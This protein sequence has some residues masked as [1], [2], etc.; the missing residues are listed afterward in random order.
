MR[1][2]KRAQELDPLAQ[3]INYNVAQ[4]YLLKNAPAPAIEQC[5][6]IIELYPNYPRAHKHLGFAYLKQRHCEEATAE[7]LKAVELSGRAS[8]H[9]R[10]LGYCYAV[11][12]GVRMRLGY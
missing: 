3:V 6:K 9:L 2:I 4:Q 5:Q 11:T 8:I 7:F 12:G 10:G 1:E